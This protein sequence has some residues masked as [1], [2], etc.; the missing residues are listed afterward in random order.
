MAIIK[1]T[2]AD[3]LKTKNVTPNWYSCQVV[4]VHQPTKAKDS[5]TINY[6]FDCVILPGQ[7]GEG[8]EIPAR[9]NSALIGKM[10]PFYSACIGKQISVEDGIDTDAFMGKKFDGH[11]TP[12]N[13]QGQLYDNFDNFVPFGASKD[14]LF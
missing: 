9:F 14:L 10:V 11:V 3:I 13:Y 1:I 8:K 7:E 5:D 12:N 4:K 6:V 2:K